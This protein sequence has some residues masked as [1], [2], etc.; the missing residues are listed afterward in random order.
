ML[1][2]RRGGPLRLALDRETL[3][4]MRPLA[5]T[6]LAAAALGACGR[7][8]DDGDEPMGIAGTI[9]KVKAC[10]KEEG[11][12]A[13]GGT[14]DRPAEDDNAPDGELVTSGAT[15][16]AFYA[17]E[18]RADDLAAELRSNAEELGGTTTRHGTITVLYTKVPE[19]RSDG[20]PD[21]RIEGCVAG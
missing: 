15:F 10:L 13:R 2:G 5:L 17:S 3:L 9:E 4:R 18:R 21:E 19:M 7:G 16:I 8:S 12:D 6:L 1:Q 11:V 14:Y 20:E